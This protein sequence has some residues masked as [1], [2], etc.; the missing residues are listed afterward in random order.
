M[1]KYAIYL[2]KSNNE[3]LTRK[4]KVTTTKLVKITISLQY[5]YK[6]DLPSNQY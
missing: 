5:L 2:H 1:Q 4:K 6:N 3:Q